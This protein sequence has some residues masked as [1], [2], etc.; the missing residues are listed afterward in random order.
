MRPEVK[1][2]VE[3][4]LERPPEPKGPPPKGASSSSSRKTSENK[5]RRP[6]A[7]LPDTALMIDRDFRIAEGRPGHGD[8]PALGSSKAAKGAGKGAAKHLK[9]GYCL[10]L[11]SEATRKSLFKRP[12]DGQS[13]ALGRP[14][15]ALMGCGVTTVL[16]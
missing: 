12:A 16:T 13:R 6:R 5:R 15:T 2:S 10:T 7:Y 8:I 3:P 9:P 4:P 1:R 11:L 14:K